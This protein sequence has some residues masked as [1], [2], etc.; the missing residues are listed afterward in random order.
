MKYNKN[1][2]KDLFSDTDLQPSEYRNVAW[3]LNRMDKDQQKEWLDL[4]SNLDY[5]CMSIEIKKMP[6]NLL[7]CS[8]QETA[9]G[10]KVLSPVR[11][12][13]IDELF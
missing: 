6:Y 13:T 4:L 10:W 2:V 3:C 12:K 5:Y 8:L 7:G 11:N 9:C 1:N